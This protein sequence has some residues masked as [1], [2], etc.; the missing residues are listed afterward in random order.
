MPPF[1]NPLLRLE[2]INT[3][4]V[5]EATVDTQ[6]RGNRISCTGNLIVILR[7]AVRI[8]IQRILRT[9]NQ[10]QVFANAVTHFNIQRQLRTDV[11]DW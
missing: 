7:I 11:I 5:V 6:R 10:L 9:D 8:F 4:N 1:Y 3:A 2:G